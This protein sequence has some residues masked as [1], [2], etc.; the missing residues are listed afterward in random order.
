MPASKYTPGEKA[1]ALS[2]HEELGPAEAARQTG[3]PKNTIASWAK[4]AGVQTVAAAATAAAIEMAKLT[5]EQKRESFRDDL[6]E[7]AIKRLRSMDDEMTL[8]TNAAATWSASR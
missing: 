4:R 8:V 3:I 6:L 1:T 5:R 2:L 7:G